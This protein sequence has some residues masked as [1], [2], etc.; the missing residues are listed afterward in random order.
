MRAFQ[1]KIMI[2]NSKPP[3]WRRVIVPAGITFS[4]L[5]MILNE[6]MDW[7]G[8]HLFEFE[9]YHEEL[10][11]LE[12]PD[13][14]DGFGYDSYDYIEASKTFIREYLENNDWFTYTYDFGDDWQHRVTI[15]KVIED[16]EY[17]YPQVI[18]YKGDSP[19]EDCG[20]IYGYYN[21]LDIISDKKNSEYRETYD[22]MKSQGYPKEYDMDEVNER[23]ERQYYYKW[24][25]AEKRYQNDIYA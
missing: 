21:C 17:N 1:L 8:Y 7:C 25:R 3:I 4:Q 5:S 19:I 9:F 13:D 16:Y 2:K 15:E 12:E 22:W 20:G 10:R 6:V 14:I 11:I 23:L 24:G 18:K